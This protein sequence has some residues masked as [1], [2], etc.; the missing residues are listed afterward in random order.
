MKRLVAAAGIILMLTLIITS[1]G[2]LDEANNGLELFKAL[3]WLVIGAIAL[4]AFIDD[5]KN[6]NWP[7]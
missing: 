3:L 6:N 1:A 7:F 2:K 4:V 5:Y